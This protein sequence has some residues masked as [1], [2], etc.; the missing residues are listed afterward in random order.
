MIQLNSLPLSAV[1]L[2][3]ISQSI[4]LTLLNQDDEARI[5]G[6]RRS[7]QSQWPF[8]AALYAVDDW[9]LC[10]G[11]VWDQWHIITAAHCTV[12]YVYFNSF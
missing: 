8:V 3:F 2:V 12:L 9:F 5:V 6:G 10:G 4:T 7:I 1:F 11:S